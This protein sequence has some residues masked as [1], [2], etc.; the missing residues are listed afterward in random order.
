MEHLPKDGYSFGYF[1]SDKED[2]IPGR[3]QRLREE[4]DPRA[5]TSQRL[6]LNGGDH[7]W[8]DPNVTKAAKM[9]SEKLGV[10]VRL[11]NLGD[12]MSRLKA[13]V[14]MDTLPVVEGE[15]RFG[16]RHAFA[17]IGGT[18]SSRMYVKQANYDCQNKLEHLLEPLNAIAVASGKRSRAGLIKHAWKY[19]LQSQDHDVIC[20][21]SID[22]VYEET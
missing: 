4:I 8:S 9:I 11:T 17:V 20:G 10:N 13:E 12:Y 1:G 19:V 16:I 14:K 5:Q 7:H 2:E 15:M 6:V 18:A 21:S 22:S 3:F